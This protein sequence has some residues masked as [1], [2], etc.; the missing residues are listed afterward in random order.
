MTPS[1]LWRKLVPEPM[2]EMMHST[3]A[4]TAA[5]PSSQI[6]VLVKIASLTVSFQPSR[7]TPNSASIRLSSSTGSPITLKKS[8]SMRST[9]SAPWPRTP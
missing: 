5:P 7:V 6:P 9:S 2:A 3:T 1:A 8:P 4:I